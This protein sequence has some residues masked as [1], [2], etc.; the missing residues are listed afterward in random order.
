MTYCDDRSIREYFYRAY[1]TRACSNKRDNQYLIHQILKL[2]QEKA[3]LLE[4]QDISDLLLASRM[5]KNGTKA[6]RFVDEL[7]EKTESFSN[8]EHESLIKFA[9]EQLDWTEEVQAWDLSYIAEKQKKA[10]CGFDAEVLK[11]YFELQNVMQGMFKI[12]ERLYQVEVEPREDISKWHQDVM[13]FYLKEQVRRYAFYA[14][15]FPER[16]SR[17]ERDVSPLV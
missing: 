17:V 14:D 12:V 16:V 15:L 7:I 4:Y 1:S 3:D 11:P 6:K 8:K 13:T 5:V 2:R 9:Q 10:E